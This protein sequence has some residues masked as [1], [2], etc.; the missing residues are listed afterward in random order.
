MDLGAVAFTGP[1]AREAG[2]CAQLQVFRLL[3]R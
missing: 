1:L 2:C 3:E